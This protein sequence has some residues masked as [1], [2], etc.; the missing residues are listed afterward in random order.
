MPHPEYFHTELTKTDFGVDLYANSYRNFVYPKHFHETFLIQIIDE[1]QN[2]FYCNGTNYQVSRKELVLINPG[3]VHTGF[4]SKNEFLS[5]K[6]FYPELENLMALDEESFSPAVKDFTLKFTK[7][8]IRDEEIIKNIRSLYSMCR[9]PEDELMIKETYQQVLLAIIKKYGITKLSFEEN[10]RQYSSVIRQA[11][12][13]IHDNLEKKLSLDKIAQQACLSPFH[14]LRVFKKFTGIT[15]HQYIIS[16]RVEKSKHL[17]QKK[18][19][20]IGD[21]YYKTGFQDH[22]HFTKVF[23]KLTGL[24]PKSYKKIW[25]A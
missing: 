10:V 13:F 20:K 4:A 2:Q 16:L 24:K 17:L 15:L 3:E 23:K 11:Q 19:V 6:V 21:I 7:T 22:T 9:F 18:G 5:Y 12:E 1:G 14:F 25:S 8:V